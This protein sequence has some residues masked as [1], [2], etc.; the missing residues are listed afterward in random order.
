MLPL[1]LVDRLITVAKCHWKLTLFADSMRNI[2]IN[3]VTHMKYF[4][5]AMVNV[6]NSHLSHK[7]KWGLIGRQSPAAFIAR[8][9]GIWFGLFVSYSSS[10]LQEALGRRYGFLILQ[11]KFIRP[12]TICISK[13][14][15]SIRLSQWWKCKGVFRCKQELYPFS[16]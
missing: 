4:I 12:F 3:E 14:Y 13:E 15:F 5:C 16:C 8:S 2:L 10:P 1:T 7:P 11:F 6:K 9:R